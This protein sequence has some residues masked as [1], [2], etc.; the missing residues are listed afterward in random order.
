MA[1]LNNI[2]HLQVYI[3]ICHLLSLEYE[4]TSL[5]SPRHFVIK[6]VEQIVAC[7]SRIDMRFKPLRVI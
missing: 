6:S 3:I 2:R 4:V 1:A 7:I 5:L